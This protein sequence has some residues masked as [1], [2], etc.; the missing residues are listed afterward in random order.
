MH[1]NHPGRIPRCLTVGERQGYQLYG[2]STVQ[3][4]GYTLFML[5]PAALFGV[6]TL[7]RWRN[8]GS[9]GR[10]VPRRFA[11][12]C[13]VGPTGAPWPLEH[14]LQ[15]PCHSDATQDI[16]PLSIDGV[17]RLTGGVDCSGVSSAGKLKA[18]RKAAGRD[19]TDASAEYL[20][21]LYQLSYS[22]I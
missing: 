14:T 3:A 7:R 8:P 9:H 22:S 11:P 18:I 4:S 21:A 19:R 12:L 13:P 1:L 6:D 5:P 10:G 2:S 16:Q 15:H 20:A 17:A